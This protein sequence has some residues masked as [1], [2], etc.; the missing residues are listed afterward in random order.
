MKKH[1]NLSISIFFVISV[2]FCINGCKLDSIFNL[3]EPE[4]VQNLYATVGSSYANFSW[5]NP[6]DKNFDGVQISLKLKN[7]EKV[8]EE[9]ISLDGKKSYEIEKYNIENLQENTIY[10]FTIKTLNKKGKVS[11]GIEKRIRTLDSP[12]SDKGNEDDSSD[13]ELEY[14]YDKSMW[15]EWIRTSDYRVVYLITG[16]NIYDAHHYPYLSDIKNVSLEKE[17]EKVLIME[18][19]GKKSRLFRKNA[20]IISFYANVV[21]ITSA[22]PEELSNI[23]VTRKNKYNP[24]DKETVISDEN[25]LAQ[26]TD[27]IAGETYILSV[28]TED[29]E[30]VH[31]EVK[32]TMDGE[33]V[34]IIP[35]V[36]SGCNFK[37]TCSYS[38]DFLF[39]NNFKEYILDLSISNIANDGDWDI[40]NYSLYSDDSKLKITNKT[41]EIGKTIYPADITCRVSYGELN[42]PYKDVTIKIKISSSKKTWID[43]FVLRFYKDPV[44]LTVKSTQSF[45]TIVLMPS[46]TLY[47]KDESNC[48]IK[49]PQC[50]KEGYE[51]TLCFACYAESEIPYE[52]YVS[53]DSE[54]YL[55]SQLGL[56]N[57]PT[58][59]YEIIHSYEENNSLETATKI[60]D[61]ATQTISF[62]RTDDVDYFTINLEDIFSP[63]INEIKLPTVGVSAAGKKVKGF[64]KGT[65]FVSPYKNITVECDSEEIKKSVE[66][67]VLD[68]ETMY[69]TLQIPDKE[70]EYPITINNGIQ[71]KTE[72]FIAKKYDVQTGDFILQDGTIVKKSYFNGLTEDELSSIVGVILVKNSGLPVVVGLKSKTGAWAGT[73]SDENKITFENLKVD[74]VFSENDNSYS[75]NYDFGGEKSWEYICDVENE[76]TENL[77]N[78]YPI[79]GYAN[80]YGTDFPDSF[81]NKG[82]YIPSIV[83]LYD[84]YSNKE[85]IQSSLDLLN[86]SL[87]SDKDIWSSSVNFK[88]TDSWS[89]YKSLVLDLNTG[90]I[91]EENRAESN[92]NEALV[93]YPLHSEQLITYDYKSPVISSINIPTV[94]EGYVGELPIIING[95][96]LTLN[97]ITSDD[98]TFTICSVNKTKA[99]AKI[100]CDGIV[101]KKQITISCGSE[102]KVVDINVLEKEKCFD[103]DD[104]GKIVLKDGTIVA[105]EDFDSSTMTAIAVV[106]SLKYNGS[107]FF[108][109]GLKES[110][111]TLRWSGNARIDV[112]DI[113][114]ICKE[115]GSQMEF[116]GDLEGIDNWDAICKADPSGTENPETNYPIFDFANKYGENA[117]LT[118]TKF[119]DNWFI[120]SI[121]EMSG[122]YKNKEKIQQSL[123]IV[124][125]FDFGEKTYWSSS[126]NVDDEYYALGV[127][128]SNGEVNEKDKYWNKLNLFVVHMFNL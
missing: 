111:S 107:S 71:Q 128:F 6:D 108:G 114:V 37:T 12:S 61:A 49:I 26:F 121:F 45:S 125:G 124:E 39:G 118:E 95:E 88:Y 123:D 28:E 67:E 90:K 63:R 40:Y 115:N 94:G 116:E 120:P 3:T 22:N 17:N 24:Y 119:N 100:S 112:K 74:Y 42:E 18:S 15:G 27:A 83:E 98:S 56:F 14:K 86:V 78:D 110:P 85:I 31:C 96:L 75:F 43:S 79:F 19:D 16:M 91:K 44:Y 51:Y 77:E 109:L 2:L 1:F 52:F 29:G 69:I 10:F 68:N 9:V 32:P 5:D 87:P 59:K 122:I 4:D 20:G 99:V 54:A 117:G 92:T 8:I 23:K 11:R 62:L 102:T 13:V 89:R 35:I 93:F 30:S 76:D 25:G 127:N 105:P 41:G 38:Y 36:D 65:N 126:Q 46:K 60:D 64:V 73:Y 103:E 48:Q 72:K 47:V 70:G 34:G 50:M 113:E 81:L 82:W 84:L 33:N 55:E 66:T 21:Q 58:K 57:T 97:E 7:G 104:I 53:T 106:A 80:K 101:N